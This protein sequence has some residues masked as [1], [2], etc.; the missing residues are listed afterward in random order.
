MEENKETITEKEAFY[1]IENYLRGLIPN[2]IISDDTLNGVLVDANVAPGTLMSEVSQKDKDIAM[3][4]LYMLI[5]NILQVMSNGRAPNCNSSLFSPVN[6]WRNGD[7]LTLSLIPLLLNGV[8]RGGVIDISANTSS[9][10]RHQFD[11]PPI[12][13]LLRYYTQSRK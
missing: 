9:Y 4:Y 13:S 3:A 1:T 6:C 5:G 10:D 7:F 8:C 2:A 12:P 11:K